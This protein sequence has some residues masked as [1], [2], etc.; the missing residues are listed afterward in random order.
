MLLHRVV[1]NPLATPEDGQVRLF[2]LLAAAPRSVPVS[3]SQ[4][5]LRYQLA[6]DL[7]AVQDGAGDLVSVRRVEPEQAGRDATGLAPVYRRVPG[8]DLVVP[9]GRLHVRFDEGDLVENHREDLRGVGYEVDS[10]PPYAPH[11]A[12]VRAVTGSLTEALRDMGRLGGLPAVRHVE[13][14]MLGKRAT[15]D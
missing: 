1:D 14:Q 15:R 8:G 10:V 4:P 6:D 13:P 2:E 5:D 11:A 3:S 7:V 12:W 9:T